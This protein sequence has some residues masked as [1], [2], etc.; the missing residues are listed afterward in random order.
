MITKPVL[1]AFSEI[2][3]APSAPG[4]YA[5]YYRQVITNF[6]LNS[7][8]ERLREADARQKRELVRCFLAR[9]VFGA[10]ESPPYNAEIS[11]PLAPSYTGELTHKIEITEGLIQRICEAPERLRVIKE[12][13]ESAVP[14]FA[15]PIYIGMSED[16]RT[17]LRTHKRLIGTY[18]SAE[19]RM[20]VAPSAA[21]P[22]ASLE[23]HSFAKE[24]VRRQFSLNGLVV[25][26]RTIKS[27]DSAHVDAENVLN[28]INYPI[29]GRN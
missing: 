2:E 4:V 11:A 16:L 14:E 24:V 10:F 9:H 26:V 29:C 13:L 1:L 21:A 23:D 8:L 28:R 3:S 17:R 15:T 20:G 12:V 22:D 19:G 7:L 18:K 25:A 6:D 5:W 27:R